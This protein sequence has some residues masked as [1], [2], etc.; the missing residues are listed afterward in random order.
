[1]SNIAFVR[2]QRECK[3]VV[4]N[5]EIQ[6]TGIMIE[7]LN[8]SLTDIKG[9][10]KG[11]PDSPYEGGTFDISIVIPEQYPFIPPKAKFITKIWHP[12][13]SSQTG[14]ICLDILKDQWAASLTLRTVLLSIQSLMCS[15]EP[16]DPQDAVVA[17]QYMDDPQ[18]FKKTAIFW[19][20]R[21]AK[22]NAPDCTDFR[23]KITKLMDMG[24]TEDEAVSVL[25]CNAWDLSKA[26]DYIFS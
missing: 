2:I 17:R 25:S 6:D 19:T 4:T 22:G 10:I 8:D 9:T 24:V 5:K 20:S 23:F 11:P 18:L 14:I 7:I 16:K 15:P 12:N 1:M 21:F 13:I 26:T 3:E